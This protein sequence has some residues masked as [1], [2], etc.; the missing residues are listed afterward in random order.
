MHVTLLM[1]MKDFAHKSSRFLSTLSY[2]F[3][4]AC[5]FVWPRVCQLFNLII[6]L[7]PIICL[8]IY[9][10]PKY[11][12]LICNWKPFHQLRQS[13][14]NSAKWSQLKKIIDL[15]SR[16]RNTLYVLTFSFFCKCSYAE[17]TY[18]RQVGKCASF[19]ICHIQAFSYTK[20]YAT[21]QSFQFFLHVYFS[22]DSNSAIKTFLSSSI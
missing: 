22:A 18:H 9:T 1:S 7:K 15:H 14:T 12:S 16:S 5:L 21:I 3:F 6:F 17:I 4:L 20:H 2:V 19:P 8:Y 11:F 10:F 13:D